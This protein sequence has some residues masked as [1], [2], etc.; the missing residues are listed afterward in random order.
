MEKKES[1]LQET[2]QERKEIFGELTT[3]AVKQKVE[4]KERE[5]GSRRESWRWK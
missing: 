4:G 1:H 2:E 3:V 5:E